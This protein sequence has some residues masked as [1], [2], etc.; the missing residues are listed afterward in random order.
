MKLIDVTLELFSAVL[1]DDTSKVECS[2]FDDQHGVFIPKECAGKSNLITNFFETQRMRGVDLNKSFHKSWDTIINSSEAKLHLQALLHYVS[3]Y[4]TQFTGKTYIPDEVLDIEGLKL[5]VI[6]VKAIT[7]D[8]LI[9]KMLGMLQSGI[10]LK[11]ETIEKLLFIADEMGYKFKSVDDIKNKEAQSII[12]ERFHVYPS[13]PAEM[14]RYLIFRSTGET[15]LIKNY[16]TIE[17]IKSSSF[18]PTYMMVEYGLEKLASVFYRFKPLFLA[19]KGHCPST[20]NKIRRLAKRY[21][22][23]LVQNPLMFVTSRRLVKGDLHWLDNATNFALLRALCAVHERF[24]GSDTFTY[25]I[26]S[27]VTHSEYTPAKNKSVLKANY[28]VLVSYI[29]NRFSFLKDKKVYIPSFIEYGLPT[30]EKQFVGN[31]PLGTKVY[32]ENPV[33]GC[34]WENAWGCRDL[35]ISA[36][37]I[38]GRRTGWN[39]YYKSNGLNYSGDMTNAPTGAIEYMYAQAGYEGRNILSVN[40]F[41]LY[42]CGMSNYHYKIVVGSH[43]NPEYNYM[44]NPE[45]LV[46]ECDTGDI[47]NEKRQTS[48]GM[49][50]YDESRAMNYFY[51]NFGMSGSRIVAE[52]GKDNNSLKSFEQKVKNSLTLNDLL[53]IILG[54]EVTENIEDMVDNEDVIDLSPKSVTKESFIELLTK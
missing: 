1:V 40:A 30:S 47:D 26:R 27:G 11:C 48:I 39:S 45:N 4:G 41:S 38:D 34:Y 25:H 42:N 16:K 51:L 15:L 54:I 24:S 3:T 33:V 21:H 46:F 17:A 2:Y 19:Y 13:N 6:F 52:Y 43:D 9:E 5:P 53:G 49:M 44:M 12:I 22:K 35:D 8:E 23:P 28:A 20:I 50:A 31:I 32:A 37:D 10:A 14:M 29:K 7:K 18:N 36:Q